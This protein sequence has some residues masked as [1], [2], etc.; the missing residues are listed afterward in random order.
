MLLR[1]RRGDGTKRQ[2]PPAALFGRLERVDREPTAPRVHTAVRSRRM[3]QP[4]SKAAT[5]GLRA[6]LN[7]GALAGVGG[8]PNSGLVGGLLCLT[9][10]VHVARPRVGR[11]LVFL[12]A[13]H[14]LARPCRFCLYSHLS[15]ASVLA[16]VGSLTCGEC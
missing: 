5:W 8:T 4:P 15:A 6:S 11:R 16:E 3:S 1:N 9:G 14:V 13:A 10:D 7:L 12:L 2:T